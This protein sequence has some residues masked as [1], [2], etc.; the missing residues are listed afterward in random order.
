MASL[1]LAEIKLLVL[2][3]PPTIRLWGVLGCVMDGPWE[4]IMN[5]VND[6]TSLPAGPVKTVAF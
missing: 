3:F 4:V 6:G 1:V 5:G 2:L